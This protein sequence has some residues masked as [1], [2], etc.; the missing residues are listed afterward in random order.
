MDQFDD[1]IVGL[2][3]GWRSVVIMGVI[4]PILF[5]KALYNE[6]HSPFEDYDAIPIAS[7]PLKN[8]VNNVPQSEKRTKA[9]S[10]L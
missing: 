10:V 9:W 2:V 5:S 6:A 8:P 3:W 7:S 1:K 4:A